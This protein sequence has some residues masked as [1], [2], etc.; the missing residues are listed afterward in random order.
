MKIHQ[1]GAIPYRRKK[2][3]IEICLVT[4]RRG[5]WT[6]PKGMIDGSDSSVET[7]LKEAH[8]EAGL[9]GEIEGAPVG[10][11]R[12]EKWQRLLN[13]ELHLMRVDKAAKEWDEQDSRER[14]WFSPE[15]AR[16]A[17]PH[18]TLRVLLDRALVKIGPIDLKNDED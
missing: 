10:L 13:V 2:G 12:Y 6:F 15:G 11:Y 14:R 5:L 17:L 7:A 3:Q 8:E 1:A 9:Y 16:D 18:E 4:S